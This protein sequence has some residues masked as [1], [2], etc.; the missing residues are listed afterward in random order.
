M[1]RK[2]MT[3]KKQRKKG[4]RKCHHSFRKREYFYLVGQRIS[5]QEEGVPVDTPKSE[6]MPPPSLTSLL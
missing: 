2:K 1:I 5:H 4:I 6:E 3:K